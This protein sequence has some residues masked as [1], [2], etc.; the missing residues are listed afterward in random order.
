MVKRTSQRDRCNGRRTGACKRWFSSYS[1]V[2]MRARP[3][4]WGGRRVSEGVRRERREVDRERSRCSGREGRCC[5]DVDAGEAIA[6]G[7]GRT[8]THRNGLPSCCKDVAGDIIAMRKGG[9]VLLKRWSGCRVRL[10]QGTSLQWKM[11]GRGRA[12]SDCL[13]VVSTSWETSLQ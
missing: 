12:E 8:R 6:M 1:K 3:L 4:Q 7:K 13:A 10:M 11:E 2:V 5:G 9:R